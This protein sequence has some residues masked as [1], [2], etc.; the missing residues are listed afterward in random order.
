[1]AR[2][3]VARCSLPVRNTRGLARGACPSLI[4]GH[5]S[6]PSL[7]VF[8]NLLNVPS[9]RPRLSFLLF[10]QH[11]ARHRGGRTAIP[12]LF[13]QSSAAVRRQFGS[14]SAAVRQQSGSSSAAALHY[15]RSCSASTL[16][17]G[18]AEFVAEP[19]HE[20]AKRRSISRN[21]RDETRLRGCWFRGA[22]C[23]NQK[24]HF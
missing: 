15:L 3:D 20:P 9:N 5:Q 22:A 6:P 19:R 2:C 4:L 21:R 12:Q 17:G 1:M 11:D 13:R 8:A 24:T 18:S 10:A 16:L 14:G 7:Y 23:R